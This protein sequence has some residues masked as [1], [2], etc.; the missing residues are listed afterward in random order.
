MSDMAKDCRYCAVMRV[1]LAPTFFLKQIC[2]YYRNV[3]LHFV[4]LH[5]LDESSLQGNREVVCRVCLY[6][7]L[8]P[9]EGN[10]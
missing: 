6:V 8:N 2:F 1:M 4:G 9:T 7:Y 10:I 5:M 3:R